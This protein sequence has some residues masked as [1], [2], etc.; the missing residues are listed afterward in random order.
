MLRTFYLLLCV[1]GVVLPYSQ[2]VPFLIAHGLDLPELLR[3]LFQN[4]ISSFFGLDV[5]ISTVVLWVFVFT[6]GPRRGIKHL[7]IYLLCSLTVGLSLALP[8]FLWAL[9]G[10]IDSETKQV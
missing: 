6:T 10:Q 4:R 8:L 7:W 3:Q 1:V 9:E 2:F 5:I